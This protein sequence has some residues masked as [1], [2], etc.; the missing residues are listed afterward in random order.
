MQFLMR[1]LNKVGIDW[2]LVTLAYNMKRMHRMAS[3]QK[4]CA[5][6]TVLV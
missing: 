1:G 5:L 6:A 3:A 4:S 2:N